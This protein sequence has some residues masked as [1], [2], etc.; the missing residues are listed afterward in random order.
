[1][2]NKVDTHLESAFQRL[3]VLDEISARTH[4]RTASIARYLSQI[5]LEYLLPGPPCRAPL[6]ATR[7]A[8]GCSHSVSVWQ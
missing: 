7:T 4:A 6:A 1:M 2:V 3:A 8:K 5:S